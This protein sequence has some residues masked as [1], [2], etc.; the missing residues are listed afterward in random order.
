MKHI[1]EFSGKILVEANDQEDALNTLGQLTGDQLLKAIETTHPREPRPI[2][3]TELKGQEY[4][5]KDYL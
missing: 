4:D 2:E 5:A 1:I 3:E